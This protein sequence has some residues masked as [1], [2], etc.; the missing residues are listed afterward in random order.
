MRGARL[1][2]VWLPKHTFTLAAADGRPVSLDKRVR[3][4]VEGLAPLK[5]TV[6]ERQDHMAILG[7]WYYSSWRDGDWIGYQSAAK[8]S[9][10]RV[11]GAI[12]RV[13]KA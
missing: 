5:V 13:S 8:L 11:V 12:H 1:G 10:R 4:V 2:G 6:A 3:E 7:R 9:Y